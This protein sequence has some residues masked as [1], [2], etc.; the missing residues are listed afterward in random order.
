M[1]K[2]RNGIM[3]DEMGAFFV[4]GPWWFVIIVMVLGVIVSMFRNNNPKNNNVKQFT[5]YEPVENSTNTI[6]NYNIC[7]NCGKKNSVNAK[8]CNG[9]GDSLNANNYRFCAECGEKNSINAKYC[10]ECG[11][12]L[13]I[14]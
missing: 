8:F 14:I 10:K 7:L 13:D 12:E 2:N 4:F 9:C 3:K 6:E 1:H 11:N 5:D